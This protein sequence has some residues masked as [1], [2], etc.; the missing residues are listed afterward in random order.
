MLFCVD[1]VV[2]RENS[3]LF[4][5][6]DVIT[7]EDTEVSCAHDVNARQ[8]TNRNRSIA[9]FCSKEACAKGAVF[10]TITIT[11]TITSSMVDLND[12]NGFVQ[13]NMCERCRCNR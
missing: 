7:R 12:C 4:C 8:D 5:A 2:T 3:E 11:V 10:S 6:D 1:G 13:V 9:T